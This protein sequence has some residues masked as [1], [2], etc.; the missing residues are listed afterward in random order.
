MKPLENLRSYVNNRLPLVIF[1]VSVST[2]AIA[3]LTIGYFFKIKEIKPPEMT[4]VGGTLTSHWYINAAVYYRNKDKTHGVG[5]FLKLNYTWLSYVK[6]IGSFSQAHLMNC[7]VIITINLTILLVMINFKRIN[8]HKLCYSRPEL[9]MDRCMTL[10]PPILFQDWNTFLLRFNKI[11]F[12]VLEKETLKHSL[13]E[14]TTPESMV[15]SSQA[16]SSTQARCCWR[17]RTPSTSLCLS[18][19]PWTH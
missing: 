7:D 5:G 6:V 1:T 17:I 4:E 10:S 19:S 8:S 14:S 9:Q 13:N 11:D 15:T 12:Y 2:V 3:F 18:P 16:R